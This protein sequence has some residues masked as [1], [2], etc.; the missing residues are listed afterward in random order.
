MGRKRSREDETAVKP[1]KKTKFLDEDDSEGGEGFKINQ[2]FA[3]RFEYNNKLKERQQRK[4][5]LVAEPKDQY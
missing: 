4:F 2:D 3:K 5:Y 1:E